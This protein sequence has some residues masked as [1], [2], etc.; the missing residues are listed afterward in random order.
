LNTSFAKENPIARRSKKTIVDALMD[1]MQEKSFDK[2][3]IKEIMERA[4]MARRT[5]YG[6][7][8]SKDEIVQYYFH[9]MFRR[10]ED[11]LKGEGK[12]SPKKMTETLFEL[13]LEDKDNMIVAR[14]QGLINMAMVEKYSGEIVSL[15]N[16][17]G[18]GNNQMA[19]K[20]A[21][22]FYLGGVWRVVDQWLGEGAKETPKKMAEMFQGIMNLE[23]FSR[24]QQITQFDK[25][26]AGM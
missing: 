20:Y 8:N 26:K 25:E 15:F 18:V 14:N 7:F 17:H 10:L 3:T 1:L 13:V 11:R 12:Y 22:V 16:R 19:L 9:N 4:D 23:I 6:N 21:A 24:V 5:F 2:I